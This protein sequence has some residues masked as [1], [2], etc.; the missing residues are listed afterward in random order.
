[1]GWGM[2][3]RFKPVYNE[4]RKELDTAGH[5]YKT[6]RFFTAGYNSPYEIFNRHNEVW[7]EK[8]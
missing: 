5:S 1:M 6:G 7:I 2:W 4:L 8:K 3:N